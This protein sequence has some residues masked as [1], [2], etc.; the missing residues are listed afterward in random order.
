MHND[1]AF[2]KIAV[3]RKYLSA[4]LAQKL[5][6]KAKQCGHG[7]EDLALHLKVL[8]PKRVERIRLHLAYKTTRKE[9]KSLVQAAVRAKHIT[10]AQGQWVLKKQRAQFEAD[11]TLV[12]CSDLLLRKG[13]MTPRELRRLSYRI[14]PNV[15][16]ESVAVPQ[17]EASI[18]Q[19]P[20][21][22]EIDAAVSRVERYRKVQAQMSD[23]AC[24]LDTSSAESIE[25]ACR[26]KAQERSR[27]FTEDR[28]L[29]LMPEDPAPRVEDAPTW[30]EPRRRPKPKRRTMLQKLFGTGAA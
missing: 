1:R 19:T 10:A 2:L 25:E 6:R 7:V 14:D 29:D 11:R 9:D 18:A 12:R 15:V 20:S 28:P 17:V 22:K 8:T 16:A 3:Q 30:E 5:Y 27:A 23:S 26:R 13:A 24:N 4:E 21:Y